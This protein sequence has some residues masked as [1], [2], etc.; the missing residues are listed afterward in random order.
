MEERAD[1][2]KGPA[3]ALS[4]HQR[5][6]ELDP[7]FAMGYSNVG[8]DYFTLGQV[9]RASVYFAKAFQLREHVSEWEK[10]R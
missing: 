6:I 9:E 7:N 5:A 2:E 3:A 1:D 10:L 4:Y 8:R